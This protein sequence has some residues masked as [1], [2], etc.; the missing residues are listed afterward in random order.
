[1]PIT[2]TVRSSDGARASLTFDG[3]QRVVIGRGAGSDVRL[4]D[5]SVSH[6]HASVRA[7]GSDLLLTDEGST[8]GTFAGGVRIAPHTSRIVRS[9][10]PVRVGRVWLEVE[11]EQ[12]PATRELAAAT[13]EIAL[14]LVS[15]AMAKAGEGTAPRVL[16]VE[17]PDRGVSLP[18]AEEGH[19]YH[20]GRGDECD[21]PLGDTDA[22]REHVSVS[23]RGGVVMVRDLGA[24]NGTWLGEARVPS[25]REI[26]WRAAQV[27]RAGRSVFALEEPVGEELARIEGVPDEVLAPEAVVEPPVPS[28]PGATVVEGGGAPVAA[29]PIDGTPAPPRAGRARLSVTDSLVVVTALGVLAASIAGLVW[30][31]RG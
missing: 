16:V 31:L 11:L 6:R 9:G 18:L 27:M 22:S 10:D 1:M 2:V 7:E 28:L 20:L 17:G 23:V 26:V 13:R 8:N 3:M 25:D 29:L 5:P 4:P 12:Q 19:V 15:R 14:A 30:L 24:K 21:L